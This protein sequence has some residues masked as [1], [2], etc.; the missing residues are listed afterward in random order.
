[1]KGDRERCLA[2]GMDAFLTKPI[3][4]VQLL[5]VVEELAGSARDAVTPRS[6][7]LRLRRLH[8]RHP[9][10]HLTGEVRHQADHPLQ[11]HELAAM[12]HLMLLHP[13][14]HFEARFGWIVRTA[15]TDW[16]RKSSDRPSSQ[17]PN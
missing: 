11:E 12:V 8:L 1:M 10:L 2:A 13:Q 3:D 17:P 4:A 7:A 9:R 15:C 6:A 5:T 16:P 14:Q